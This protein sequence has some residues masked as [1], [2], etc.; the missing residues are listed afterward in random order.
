[1]L[2]WKG[3]DWKKRSNCLTET[4][5]RS[6]C[7][8]VEVLR[9]GS[10]F[11]VP[12]MLHNVT[13]PATSLLYFLI[14]DAVY[15][16]RSRVA[17][18]AMKFKQIPSQTGRSLVSLRNDNANSITIL[19]NSLRVGKKYLSKLEELKGISNFKVSKSILDNASSRINKGCSN[20]WCY[21]KIALRLSQKLT[22]H[23]KLA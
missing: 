5:R 7:S 12:P 10:E 8:G 11:I 14:E 18:V 16:D 4:Q 20:N 19:E 2:N 3:E 13:G 21:E 17:D 6:S 23:Q 9:T 1:M 15:V 22:V